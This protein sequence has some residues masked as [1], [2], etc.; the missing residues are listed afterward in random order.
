VPGAYGIERDAPLGA[1]AGWLLPFGSR[2]VLMA[3]DAA[4]LDDAV[5][6]LIRIGY[7]G[8]QGYLEGGLEA[9]A[10]AG[11]PVDSLPRLSVSEL[12]ERLRSGEA[13]ALLDVRQDSE[14]EAGHIPDA[15]HI[16]NGRLVNAPLPWPASQPIAVYCAVG[17]RSTAGIS[18]LLRRGFTHLYLVEGGFN[19]WHKAGFETSNR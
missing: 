9:W 10:R 17:A 8:L 14:W 5:R 18:V 7:E 19:A 11:L 3:E 12:R 15:V 13:L 16:E 2:L 1:W 4:A 6:Q